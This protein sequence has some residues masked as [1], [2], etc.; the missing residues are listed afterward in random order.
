MIPPTFDEADLPDRLRR[1][2]ALEIARI[3]EDLEVRRPTLVEWWSRYRDRAPLLDTVFSRW[4]TLGLGDLALVD[5]DAMVACDA[6]YRELD[7]LRLYFQFTQDMPTTL[8]ERYG[9]ALGRVAA[10]GTLALELLGGVPER[11]LVEFPEEAPAVPELPLR[12]TEAEAEA[13][14]EDPR[15]P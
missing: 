8:D 1:V 9:A 6:F 15:H 4:R 10:Y 11:P 3:V 2:M 12:P 5:P 7:E 13:L 14:P